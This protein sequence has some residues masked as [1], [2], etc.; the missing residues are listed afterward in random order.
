MHVIYSISSQY[1]LIVKKLELYLYKLFGVNCEGHY[2][3]SKIK[4]T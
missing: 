1:I 2:I 4:E 3:G